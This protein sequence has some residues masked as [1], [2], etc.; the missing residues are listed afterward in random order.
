MQF[1]G[2][3]PVFVRVCFCLHLVCGHTNSENARPNWSSQRDCCSN[4]TLRIQA[5]TWSRLQKLCTKRQLSCKHS[6]QVNLRNDGYPR[7]QLPCEMLA[8]PHPPCAIYNVRCQLTR[9]RSERYWIG[10]SR[11]T[12][13]SVAIGNSGNF[14]L[15]TRNTGSRKPSVSEL[16]R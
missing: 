5:S 2:S 14:Y 11:R 9:S 7:R 6:F 10:K 15:L 1:L 16:M 3:D 13:K 8:Y 12:A 4:K